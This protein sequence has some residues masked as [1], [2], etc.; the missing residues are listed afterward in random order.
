MTAA[1]GTDSLASNRDLNLFEEGGSLLD[2][3][4]NI[5]PEA[6]LTM[7]TVGGAAALGQSHLFGSIEPGKRSFLLAVDVADSR[8]AP[9]SLKL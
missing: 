3:H 1:L 6:V 9:G 7:L 8:T 4:P 2:E 5:R